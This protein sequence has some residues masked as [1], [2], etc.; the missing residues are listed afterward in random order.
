MENN[1]LYLFAAIFI[2]V[3]TVLNK[4][5][6]RYLLSGYNTLSEEERN[7]FN[8]ADF[9]TFFKRSFIILGGSYLIVGLLISVFIEDPIVFT[10]YS[11]LYPLIGIFLILYTSSRFHHQNKTSWIVLVMGSLIIIPIIISIGIGLSKI[12]ITLDEYKINVSSPYGV[13]IDYHQIKSIHIQK[14]PPTVHKVKGFQM[15]QV[16][17]GIFKLADGQSITVLSNG[18]DSCFR[19]TTTQNTYIIDYDADLK[20]RL[21]KK[22]YPANIDMAERLMSQ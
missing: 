16:K 3:G 21:Y 11:I 14:M 6:A 15:V 1:V 12:K 4:K 17:K 7:K 8:L 9:L 10:I 19:I 20:K 5:N 2:I 22:I 18:K 13:T